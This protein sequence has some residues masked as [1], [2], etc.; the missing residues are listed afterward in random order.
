MHGRELF[1]GDIVQL[2]HGNY[3]GTDLEEWV[4]FDGL[5]AIVA[6]QY[7]SYSD[8]S[9]V[10]VDENAQPFTMG[11]YGCGI[12]NDEWHVALVKSHADIIVGERLKA[13]GLNYRNET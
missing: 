3:L 10:L 5:T 9:I 6:N 4:P 8:G 13:F 2:W 1:T 7:Q 11:I 12:S